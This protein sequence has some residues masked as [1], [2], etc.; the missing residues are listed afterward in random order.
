MNSKFLK[1]QSI[2]EA[3]IGIAIGAIL[4]G[5]AAF[6]I[7]PTLRSNQ[8][9]RSIQVINSLNQEYIDS[10]KNLAEAD[11]NSIYNKNKGYLYHLAVSGASY[12]ITDNSTTTQRD[13]RVF[14]R[15]F[16]IE[17][18]NRDSCGTGNITT[19]SI[20]GNCATGFP[21]GANDITE[22]FSTQ[23][24]TAVVE[25]ENTSSSRVQYITRSGNK[26]FVQTD[27]SGGAFQEN[28]P[29]KENNKFTTSTNIDFTGAPGSIIIK[30]LNLGGGSF[31][32][33][34]D[35]TYK[36]AWNDVIGWI[37]FNP[38]V[39]KVRDNY[40]EG[41][42]SSSVGYIALDCA[43]SPVPDCS[44][45][46]K[47]LNNGGVLSGWA[48]NDI[49]GWI[50]FDAATA[51]SSYFYGVTINPPLDVNPGDFSGWAWNDIVGWISFNCNNS[52][53]GDTCLNSDYKVKTNWIPAGGGISASGDLISSVFDTGI[54]NGVVLNTIMWKGTPV[55]GGNVEFQI[56]SSD[57]QNPAQWDYKGPDGSAGSFYQ[58]LD[59]GRSMK[60]NPA[61]HNNHRYFRYKIFLGSNPARTETPAV[62]DVII[63]YSP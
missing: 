45:S 12:V 9:T 28:F 8:E 26:S 44:P 1:G 39:I 17:N 35:S 38:G 36:Y 14:T 56:A 25:W 33:D 63:N 51:T 34:I 60:I 16:F 31:G 27:W 21:G 49:V 10:V 47:V 48:W 19:S 50:S 13:G 11:W 6:A 22:D 40:L 59:Q 7:L 62:I 37:D 2:I 3:I 41:Y 53:I 15:Y 42:A 23:K 30:D 20:S 54:N 5:A 18:V 4:V 46:Y 57:I 55:S 24:I 43:T 52:G 58:P 61:H 29:A 32:E